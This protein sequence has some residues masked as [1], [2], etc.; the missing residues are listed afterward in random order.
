MHVAGVH[1]Q[2]PHN[3]TVRSLFAVSWGG[4]WT[5][6]SPV[7]MSWSIPLAVEYSLTKV[8]KSFLAPLRSICQWADRQNKGRTRLYTSS[9]R[10]RRA[11][12]MKLFLPRNQWNARSRPREYSPDFVSEEET[13][14][15]LSR[16][17]PVF[18]LA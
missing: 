1:A 17:I 10:T 18:L 3:G 2:P 8:G 12:E 7:L 16:S 5:I 15:L 4:F 13:S 6:P 9:N 14:G 11:S